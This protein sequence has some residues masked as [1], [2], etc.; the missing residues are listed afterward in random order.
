MVSGGPYGLEDIIG[1]AGYKVAL[2]LL[3]IVPFFWSLPTALMVG[4]LAS[5][6]PTEGGFYIW[7]KQAMGP[8]W[9]FQEAWLSLAASV[10]DMAIYP[11]LFVLYLGRIAPTYTIGFRG[12]LWAL[13]VILAC[14]L[15]NLRGA[16]A[17]GESSIFLFCALLFP[18]VVM[19]IVALW[20]WHWHGHGTGALLQPLTKSDFAGAL[21][22]CLWNYMGWDNAST[23]AQE[24]DDPQ[25]NYP[26]AMI[27]SAVL[28]ALTYMLPVIAVALA[29]LSASQFN[30]DANGGTG[31][32]TDAARI[33]AG[34]II[35]LL[36][37][38]GGMINGAGMFN[39]LMMSYA[40]LPF[41][42]AEDGLAPKFLTRLNRAG[43]PWLSIIFCAIIWS[44]ALTLK[45][46]KLISIDLVLYGGGLILEFVAL[47]I[48][49]KREPDMH[50]PFRI[51]GPN[52]VAT[53]IGIGPT[54][55]IAFALYAAR[56]EKIAGLNAL[57]FSFLIAISG[58][59]VYA[60]TATLRR[61]P[62]A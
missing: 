45:F 9:G 12:P 53:L 36:V 35:A 21:S 44:L 20:H 10:F 18:F 49:R 33:I 34:P 39:P 13:A 61:K 54:L 30:S 38:V 50:R 43:V 58:S 7:V 2:L 28:V 41:A 15:W 51:P 57:L 24:V 62:S 32:W 6:I 40:R 47:A 17:V 25:R 22:V 5:A 48:L 23:V 29:G 11:T 1:L 37:V 3:G 27:G 60:S 8:F 56:D 26:R 4:E 46:E 19:V 42:M 16:K 55:L 52:I 59:I 31:S 14:T